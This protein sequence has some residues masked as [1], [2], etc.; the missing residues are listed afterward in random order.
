[1]MLCLRRKLISRLSHRLDSKL[2]TSLL[3]FVG[4]WLGC[5]SGCRFCSS[6][7]NGSCSPFFAFF[8]SSS[9]FSLPD[10]NRLRMLWAIQVYMWAA[11]SVTSV[12]PMILVVFLCL[13][14]IESW[15]FVEMFPIFH[16]DVR[17]TFC[18]EKRCL[19]ESNA[20]QRLLDNLKMHL[21]PLPPTL[22]SSIAILIL[23]QTSG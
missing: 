15:F 10:C 16:S 7:Y 3:F 4:F 22:K 9:G 23:L 19:H 17:M 13:F 14:N 21:S 11:C 12:F 20:P 1:M 5:K 18:H 2:I 8:N 6:I